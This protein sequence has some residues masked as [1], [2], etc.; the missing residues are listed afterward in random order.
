LVKI[1]S[2]W[3]IAEKQKQ[4]KQKNKPPPPTTT[5]KNQSNK[6]GLPETEDNSGKESG[7]GDWPPRLGGSWTYE[8]D[9]R[10]LTSLVTKLRLV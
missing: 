10:Q 3:P 6:V 5:T 7:T 8:T 2:L 4:N 1:K 9:D